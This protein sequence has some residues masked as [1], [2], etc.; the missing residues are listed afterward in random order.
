MKSERVDPKSLVSW[1]QEKASGLECQR[2]EFEEREIFIQQK[3]LL[4]LSGCQ[5]EI[6]GV[7]P[8]QW[9]KGWEARIQKEE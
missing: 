8:H 6:R 4:Q 3:R 2:A 7:R 5:E 1:A 9:I